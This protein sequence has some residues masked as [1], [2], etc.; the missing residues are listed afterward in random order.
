[1]TGLSFTVFAQGGPM[2]W[3]LLVMGLAGTLIFI[4][5]LLYLHR[6]QIRSTTFVSGIKNIL[7]KRRLMEAL[8]VCE[9]TPGPVA[10]VVKSALL[11]ADR[12]EQAMR[13]AVQAAALTEI[14]A[15]ERRLGSIAAIAQVAPL[16]GLLGTLLGMITTFHAFMQGG[17][18]SSANALAGGMWQALICTAGSLVVAIPGHLAY[19]FL[20]GRVRAVVRDVEWGGNEIMQYLLGE[21]RASPANGNGGLSAENPPS[22]K[23]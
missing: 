9:E 8:T 10:A 13:L 17:G 23:P 21:Y 22:V 12:D 3:V 4:E 11:H 6:G 1:M 14:P 18:Y 5:R 15:L 16:V 19:H 7:A 2:M 20:S